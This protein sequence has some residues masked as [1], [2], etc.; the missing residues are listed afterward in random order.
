VS[1]ERIRLRVR[2]RGHVQGVWFRESTRQQA[3]RLAVSGWVRNCAD[4]S[5][6]ALLEGVPSAVRAL[7]AWLHDGPPG[8]RVTDVKAAEEPPADERGFRVL[9]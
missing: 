6:E 7:E 8:A 1:G 9:R 2:I 4:G 3:E 5:V